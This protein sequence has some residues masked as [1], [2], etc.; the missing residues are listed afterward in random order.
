MAEEKNIVSKPIIDQKTIVQSIN[1]AKESIAL[2]ADVNVDPVFSSSMLD[3]NADKNDGYLHPVFCNDPRKMH[4]LLSH[5][6]TVQTKN[7][8]IF[9]GWV[10]TVDPVSER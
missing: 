2:S 10:Q 4:R 8:K 1:A 6:V 9:T 7:K 3:K 5:R